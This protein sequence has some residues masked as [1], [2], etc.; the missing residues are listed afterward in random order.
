MAISSL[1]PPVVVVVAEDDTLIR[2]LAADA[3]RDE[4]WVAIEA[5]EASAALDICN[6]KSGG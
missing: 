2:M 5:G 6:P 1:G 4:G 3:L